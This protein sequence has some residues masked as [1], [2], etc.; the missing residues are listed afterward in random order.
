MKTP[1][2]AFLLLLFGLTSPTGSQAQTTSPTFLLTIQAVQ[3]T[4]PAGDP[5]KVLV[6]LKNISSEPIP[7]IGTAWGDL[8]Y[9]VQDSNGKI[10][11]ETP[12]GLWA[13]GKDPKHPWSGGVFSGKL[14]PGNS[15]TPAIDEV[16][17]AYKMT[18]PGR[19]AIQAMRWDPIAKMEV[20]SNVVTVTVIPQ[21]E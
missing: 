3:A 11:P 16:S 12:Y 2:L 5:V 1:Y 17:K 7:V 15:L 10:A 9:L 8:Q 20:K 4:V 14:A 13:H 19:Y 6:N 18:A 21:V